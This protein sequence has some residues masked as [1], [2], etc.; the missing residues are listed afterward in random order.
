M[1]GRQPEISYVE[2]R[3]QGAMAKHLVIARDSTGRKRT[4]RKILFTLDNLGRWR[5]DGGGEMGIRGN[6]SS[7]ALKIGRNISSEEGE[8]SQFVP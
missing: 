6:P 5:W 8:L 4:N 7:L 3:S 1:D 2:Y